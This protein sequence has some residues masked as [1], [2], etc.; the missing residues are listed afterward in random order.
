[1]LWM[2]PS[3]ANNVLYAPDVMNLD[4]SVESQTCESWIR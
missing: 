3:P 4:Q 1:M 2:M